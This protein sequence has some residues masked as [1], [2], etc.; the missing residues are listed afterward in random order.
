LKQP[1]DDILI[2]FPLFDAVLTISLLALYLE[3]FKGHYL[4][5]TEMATW[6]DLWVDSL[7]E[8]EL[9]PAELSNVDAP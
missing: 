9:E 8:D 6:F 2:I 7:Y 1:D 5:D 3:P 4:M